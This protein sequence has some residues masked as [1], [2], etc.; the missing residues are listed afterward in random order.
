MAEE[1]KMTEEE[2]TEETV[3]TE[4]AADADKNFAGCIKSHIFA[5]LFSGR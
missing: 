5:H 4:E 1:E 3:H 2:R